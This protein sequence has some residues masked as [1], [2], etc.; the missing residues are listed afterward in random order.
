MLVFTG[1]WHGEYDKAYRKIKNLDL[2]DCVVIQVGDFGVGF[3]NNKKR[4]MRKLVNLN[5]QL[6]SRNIDLYAIRGNHDDPSYF[7]GSVQLSNVKLVADYTTLNLCGKKIL[8]VGGAVSVDRKYNPDVK[9]YRNKPWPGRKEGSNYWKDEIFVLKDIKVSDVDIVVT[10]SAPNFCTPYSKVGVEKWIKHDTELRTLCD[11]ERNS[12]TIL[13]ENLKK[14]NNITHWFYGH[15]HSSNTTYYD[16]TKF[17]LLDIL[18][19]Y[20]I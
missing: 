1:D 12:H 2:S 8:F 17:I 6:K 10:H 5:N 9:D 7:D 19:F 11:D 14:D 13:Y 15:F 16:E 20:N 3:E 18:E 4:E